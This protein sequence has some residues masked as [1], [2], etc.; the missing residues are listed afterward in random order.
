MRSLMEKVSSSICTAWLDEISSTMHVPECW[1]QVSEITAGPQP[2]T[3]KRKMTI[4][5]CILNPSSRVG[6]KAGGPYVMPRD[7]STVITEG[8]ASAPVGS[9]AGQPVY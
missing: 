8:E 1:G 7:R 9:A 6:P 5:R 2:A 3:A 4:E